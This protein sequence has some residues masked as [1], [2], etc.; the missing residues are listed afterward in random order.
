MRRRTI[1]CE[2][3]PLPMT[4]S[5]LGTITDGHPN[6]MALGWW[7]RVNYR[8]AMLGISINKMNHSCHAIMENREFSLNFPPVSLVTQTDCTGLISGKYVD[9]SG[10]FS[11]YSGILAQAPL[12]E[13]CGLA[14]ECRLVESV[15][16]PTHHFVVGEIAA[17]HADED[18]LSNGMPDMEKLQPVTLSM[19]YNRYWCGGTY[20]GQAW[21]MGRE[22]RDQ[23]LDQPFTRKALPIK[24]RR[25][26]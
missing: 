5:I 8:P 19:P 11:V 20:V 22:L 9:K 10:L 12:I 3:F 13:E 2:A 1:G 4:V 24:R 21:K 17:V 16:L 23:L 25:P 18:L 7:T 6:F 26:G 15:S 14:I